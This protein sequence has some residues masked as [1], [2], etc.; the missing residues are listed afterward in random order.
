MQHEEEMFQQLA[1]AL[2]GVHSEDIQAMAEVDL[3]RWQKYGFYRQRGKMSE[4]LKELD[5]D[6]TPSLPASLRSSLPSSHLNSCA[7][8]PRLT[9]RH[10]S[11]IEQGPMLTSPRRT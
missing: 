5:S 9:S 4:G 1:T 11:P 8:I 10:R 6:R 3:G 2:K 7:G